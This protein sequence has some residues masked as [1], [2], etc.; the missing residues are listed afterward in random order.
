MSPNALLRNGIIA[1]LVFV[2]MSWLGDPS[3]AQSE[4]PSAY[5]IRKGVGAYGQFDLA[6][7]ES[8]SIVDIDESETYRICIMGGGATVIVDDT[9]KNHLDRGDCWDVSGKKII[10]Q[11]DPNEGD[12]HGIYQRNNPHGV[13]GR[14][15]GGG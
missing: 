9:K 1:A 14:K 5:G 6:P 12:A 13:I 7:N 2:A 3:L 4:Y 15:R 10:L 11:S 8:Q